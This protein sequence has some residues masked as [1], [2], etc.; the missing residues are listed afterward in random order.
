MLVYYADSLGFLLMVIIM[1][2]SKSIMI[3]LTL[4][5]GAMAVSGTYTEGLLTFGITDIH[6]NGTEQNI[7]LCA[8]NE[9]QLHNCQSRDDAGII[10]QGRFA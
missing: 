8:Q 3:N 9:V 1:C 7:S 4:F 10:C 2:F 5:L 6:C